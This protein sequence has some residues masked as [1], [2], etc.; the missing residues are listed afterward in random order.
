MEELANGYF[1]NLVK[2][3]YNNKYSID[4]INPTSGENEIIYNIP[5]SYKGIPVNNINNLH[6]YSDEFGKLYFTYALSYK[7]D[8]GAINT[9]VNVFD[10]EN[11][12][13]N[14]I[15]NFNGSIGTII[16]DEKNIFFNISS[17]LYCFNR[18]SGAK[19]WTNY[20]I[21]NINNY[22]GFL[23]VVDNYII[24]GYLNKLNIINKETGENV[25]I[26]DGFH[27]SISCLSY[28]NHLIAIDN[29]FLYKLNLDGE[30]K[31]KYISKYYCETNTSLY[32]QWAIKTASD[33][34][35]NCD[36]GYFGSIILS[37]K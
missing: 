4:K 11:K 29:K 24:N 37:R 12:T 9:V 6:A 23:D 31:E 20:N 35:I 34:I 26:K 19:Q 3:G 18:Y 21:P 32:N 30:I 17:D 5:N 1:Y 22:S 13:V 25:L 28:K 8:R 27:G 2:D 33:E 14:E 7:N 10:F 16:L 36:K 15:Y